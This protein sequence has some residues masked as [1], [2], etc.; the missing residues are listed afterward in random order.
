MNNQFH[1]GDLKDMRFLVTGGAGFIG[2]HITDYLI[3]HGAK[4]VRVADNLSTGSFKNIQHHEIHPAFEFIETDLIVPEACMSICKDIDIVFHEAALGSVPRSVLQPLVT[5]SNNVNTHLNMMWSC[6]QNGVK[7]MVY[8]SSSSVYGDD[9]NTP[10]NEAQ[11]G[12]LL[13]PYAVTKKINELYSGVFATL[14]DLK[15]IGLRYFNVFGPRQNPEGPYAAVIPLF[16]NAMLSGNQPVIYGSGEQSRDFT[17]VDNIVQANILAAFTEH[18]EVFGS[19]MNIGAG[20]KTTVN[21]LF[22]IIAEEL[23]SDIQ[24]QYNPE[25]KGD[26][27]SS[28]ASIE[29]ARKMIGYQPYI[30]VREGIRKTI[31]SFHE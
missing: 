12:N 28:S 22:R 21:K 15:I 2:S 8:A 5:N 17:Y 26:I 29:K 31:D 27:F 30:Q 16:I 14:Y 11:T 25:R 6:L 4:K 7:R 13:S 3:G 24:P 20:G 19:V 9:V 1:K 23:K 18:T 10:K